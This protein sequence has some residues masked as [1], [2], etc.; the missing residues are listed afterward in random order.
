MSNTSIPPLSAELLKALDELYPEA[1]AD[2]RWTDRDVWFKAGQRQ[3]IRFLKEQFKRQQ[4]A[5]NV[6]YDSAAFPR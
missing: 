1:S 2:L 6:L 5:S 4:E 3:V